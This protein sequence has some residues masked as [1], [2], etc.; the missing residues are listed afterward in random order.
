MTHAS[1]DAVLPFLSRWL[2]EGEIADRIPWR[3]RDR[4]ER[5][6]ASH[7][8][9]PIAGPLT[10]AVEG[11]TPQ[12][13]LLFGGDLAFHRWERHTAPASVFDDLADLLASCDARLANLETPLTATT[14]PAGLIGASLRADPATLEVLKY[15]DM[16][17]VACANNHCLDFGRDALAE[18]VA[19]LSH[20]GIG[21][22]GIQR[23]ATGGGAT[24]TVNGLRVGLLAYTDDWRPTE[25]DA[26][27]PRPAP[28]TPADIRHDIVARHAAADLIVVQLHWGY[29]WVMYPMRSLRDLARSYADAG[30][31]LVLCHHA[32]VPAGVEVRGKAVIAYGLGNFYF[33]RSR[34]A[35]HPFR[36]RSFLLRVG[37]SAR[38]IHDVAIIPIHTMADGRV[39]CSEGRVADITNRAIAYASRR[40]GQDE[41]LARVE[42]SLVATQG[43]GLIG[44]LA[45]RLADGDLTG[46]RQRVRYLRPPRQRWL[47]AR[48]SDGD[49]LLLEIGT[50]LTELLNTPDDLSRCSSSIAALAARTQRQFTAALQHGRIP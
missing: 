17:A 30:A 5:W 11:G 10:V 22:V 18:S 34:R 24:I 47:I 28:H 23:D 20:A 45:R 49:G 31:D 4:L 44:D 50:V 8:Y 6:T 33:G 41:Y 46:A 15:L 48:L 32:H 9:P 38:T 39:T 14:T 42:R 43:C 27:Y 37:V 21:V 1:R 2:R 19:H 36:N 26:A 35:D 7:A 16:T 12:A 13:T 25:D 29:E 3:L 40:L